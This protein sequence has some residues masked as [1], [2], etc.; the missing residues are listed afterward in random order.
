MKCRT[1]KSRRAWTT[2][3]RKMADIFAKYTATL[4][5]SD[6]KNFVNMLV[7]GQAMHLKSYHLSAVVISNR[8]L[9]TYQSSGHHTKIAEKELLYYAKLAS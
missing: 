7:I 6:K 8:D 9:K 2:R 3:Q 5:E 4:K 1:T